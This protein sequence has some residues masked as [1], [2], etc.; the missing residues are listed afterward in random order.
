MTDGWN[1]HQPDGDDAGTRAERRVPTPPPTGSTDEASWSDPAWSDPHSSAAWVPPTAPP[2]QPAYWWTDARNDPWRDPQSHVR[3]GV[4]GSTP[5]PSKELAPGLGVSRR[6]AILVAV[7]AAVALMAGIVGGA[8]GVGFMTA[9]HR[10]STS[11]DRSNQTI[12]ALAQRPPESFAAIAARVLPSVVTVKVPV[13]G[14]MALGSGFVVSDDGYVITND[15]VVSG[16]SGVSVVLND[17]T[18]ATAKLIG[19]DPESDI[20][21]IK[22]NRSG[23]PPVE[24]GDSSTVQVGDPVLAVGSPLAL[25]GTVTSGIV[26]AVDRLLAAGD[27]QQ[28]RY[29]AAIQTDAA[30]NHGNSGGPLLDGGGSVIGINAVIKSM[31]SDDDSAGNIGL[32][33]AI[34]INQAKRIAEEIIST[35]HARRTVIGARL[36]TNYKGVRLAEVDP[37]GPAAAAG[38]RNGDVVLAV[39]HHVL[40]DPTE[41]IA[42]VRKYAPGTAVTVDYQRGSSHKEVTVTLA[43]DA[44]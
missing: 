2:S 9:T 37:A 18:P 3:L 1:W 29:Y 23:L 43:A 31:A 25:P 34:P 41:L 7:V 15:H 26:S 14:G 28:T 22:V 36:D 17:G 35:G 19:S 16:G 30:I 5:P 24:M 8:M 39:D 21:V 10:Q 11:L 6:T 40:E 42:L 32:A 13:S 12:A 38:L 33:F 4:A 44:K 27:S 20:A